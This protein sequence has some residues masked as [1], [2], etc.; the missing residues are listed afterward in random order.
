MAFQVVVCPH[1]AARH[2]LACFCHSIH[3]HSALCIDLCSLGKDGLNFTNEVFD[4]FVTIEG[5]N[6]K[7]N[8]FK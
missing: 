1:M 3:R 6:V 8:G 4:M 2:D 7:N 5:N